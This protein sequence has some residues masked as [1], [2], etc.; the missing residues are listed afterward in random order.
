MKNLFASK[1]WYDLIA[2]QTHTLVTTGYGSFSCLVG[3]LL[4]DFQKS[5]SRF[6]R[7]LVRIRKYSSIG[8]TTTVDVGQQPGLPTDP[9]C[10]STCRPSALSPSTCRNFH[11]SDSSLVRSDKRRICGPRSLRSLW[12]HARAGRYRLA[13]DAS[14]PEGFG[15]FIFVAAGGRKLRGSRQT[16]MRMPV[17]QRARPFTHWRNCPTAWPT[18]YAVPNSFNSGRRQMHR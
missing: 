16:S 2:D 10:W 9:Q 4:T 8:S 1:K 3:K 6:L 7:A 5:Q 14:N 15:I 18:D 12:P 17:S 13:I 11:P